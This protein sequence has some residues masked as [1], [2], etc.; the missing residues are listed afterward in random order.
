[1][2]GSHVVHVADDSGVLAGTYRLVF[3][4]DCCTAGGGSGRRPHVALVRGAPVG[5]PAA[6]LPRAAATDVA[7]WADDVPRS[8][9]IVE[10]TSVR[11]IRVAG[12]AL[13][14]EL[15]CAPAGR[16]GDGDASRFLKIVVRHADGVGGN[17]P[18]S[19]FRDLART[20]AIEFLQ[21]WEAQ[22]AGAAA[23]AAADEGAD[24]AADAAGAGEGAAAGAAPPP[25]DVDLSGIPAG[26]VGDEAGGARGGAGAAGGRGPSTSRDE[27][28]EDDEE[29]DDEEDGDAVGAGLPPHLATQ[30]AAAAGAGGGLPSSRMSVLTGGTGGKSSSARALKLKEVRGMGLLHAAFGIGVVV[31]VERGWRRCAHAKRGFSS[32][33]SLPLSRLFNSTPRAAGPGGGHGHLAHPEQRQHQQ[34]GARGAVAPPVP[35][36][37]AAGAA[38]GARDVHR[39]VVRAAR[40]RRRDRRLA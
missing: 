31:V 38:V 32:S 4:T 37:A 18:E 20:V 6:S 19:D 9:V 29:D 30:L 7:G 24:A 35:P 3:S 21:H 22:R 34:G 36:Q 10:P 25:T 1:M 13:I 12:S 40:R 39:R 17:P 15:L 27:G 8:Q 5:L 11:E 28:E 16:L 23:A 14:C 2:R 26:D 33:I